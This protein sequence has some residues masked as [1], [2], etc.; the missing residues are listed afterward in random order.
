MEINELIP[1]DV[2]EKARN[3]E[4]VKIENLIPTNV[5]SLEITRVE[6]VIDR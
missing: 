3:D 5:P 6:S 1:K 4:N 2:F